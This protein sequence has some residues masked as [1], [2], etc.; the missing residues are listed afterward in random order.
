MKQNEMLYCLIA[1]ILGYLVHIMTKGN[2]FTIGG[3]QALKCPEGTQLYNESIIRVTEE[4]GDEYGDGWTNSTPPRVFSPFPEK[5]CRSINNQDYPDGLCVGDCLPGLYPPGSPEL[6]DYKL[7]LPQCKYCFNPIVESPP[8][9]S[10]YSCSGTKCIEDENGE[11]DN[12]DCDDKC[13]PP[14]IKYSCSGTECIV[15][16]NG[17]YTD[18]ECDNYCGPWYTKWWVILIAVILAIL[19]IGGGILFA[20]RK[21][22]KSKPRSAEISKVYQ[23]HSFDRYKGGAKKYM[24]KFNNE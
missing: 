10:N 19:V 9:D 1:L 13:S 6:E 23:P 20:T 3:K 12:D 8:S 2:G 18:D 21:Q 15:K 5:W 4:Y 17:D 24:K 11:Y 22:S 14:V 16:S 7:K